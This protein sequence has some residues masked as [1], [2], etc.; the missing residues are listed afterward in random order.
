MKGA[1]LKWSGLLLAIACSLGNPD[2]IGKICTSECPGG[3]YCVDGQCQTSMGSDDPSSPDA[4]ATPDNA[5]RDAGQ[6]VEQPRTDAGPV[7]GGGNGGGPATGG[8]SQTGGGTGGGS[9]S[10][11]G[12]T[13]GGKPTGGGAG[14]G[15]AT[16][17]GTGGGAAPDP[18]LQCTNSQ[19][20]IEKKCVNESDLIGAPCSASAPCASGLYCTAD[21]CVKNGTRYCDSLRAPAPSFCADFD[22]SPPLSE[23]FWLPNPV[24]ANGELRAVGDASRSAPNLLRSV[25]PYSESNYI[26]ST[27]HHDITGSWS[28]LVVTFDLYFDFQTFQA[29]AYLASAQI[30]CIASS[31]ERYR[32][33]NLV[34][35]KGNFGNVTVL[36]MPQPNNQN[37]VYDTLSNQPPNAK[38]NRMR[39]EMSRG[40]GMLRGSVSV[41]G[42]TAQTGTVGDCS[43]EWSIVIGVG[44]YKSTATTLYDNLIF[45]Q[46]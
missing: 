18:C 3:L 10:G 46:K 33:M 39:L 16:G 13:G 5:K 11:G 36:S 23:T 21:I 8:G 15:N 35:T 42:G 22:S 6:T 28:K 9:A 4:A 17:G 29:G 2:Y 25:L 20:C 34:H 32:G 41:N 26:Q 30:L 40:N 12:G 43:G 44:G 37:N 7:T 45:E 27:V 1:G 19:R 31:G 38:W 14:G 24:P